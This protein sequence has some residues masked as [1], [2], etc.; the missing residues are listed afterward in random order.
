MK[1][2]FNK[3]TITNQ[4]NTKN[5]LNR[6]LSKVNT[7]NQNRTLADF[8]GLVSTAVDSNYDKAHSHDHNINKKFGQQQRLQRFYRLTKKYGI[9]E[10]GR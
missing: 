2:N 4:Y 5:H 8:F 10:D 6:K 9:K 3:L 1:K 7:Y